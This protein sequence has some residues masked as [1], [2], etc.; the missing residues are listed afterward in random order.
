[1]QCMVTRR[2][3]AMKPCRII[4]VSWGH[5]MSR[6]TF[7]HSIFA[8]GALVSAS[9]IAAADEGGVSFWIPGFFGSLAAT[10]QQAGWSLARI[11]YHTTGSAGG[12]HRARGGVVNKE[13][14]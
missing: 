2:A 11:Y 12:G 8:L 6:S 10:P 5:G 14:P 1:M 13:S 7:R 9:T 3:H 4:E